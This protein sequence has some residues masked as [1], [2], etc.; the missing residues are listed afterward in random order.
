MRIDRFRVRHSFDDGNDTSEYQIH[1]YEIL[2][3][4]KDRE[5]SVCGSDLEPPFVSFSLTSSIKGSAI[6]ILNACRGTECEDILENRVAEF[7]DQVRGR[8]VTGR[9]FLLAQDRAGI[10]FSSHMVFPR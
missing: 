9:Q 8:T 3:P 2:E 5:C 4:R 10:S 1:R 7:R 6:D